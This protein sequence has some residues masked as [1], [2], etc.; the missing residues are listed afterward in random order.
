MPGISNKISKATTN[1]RR[2]LISQRQPLF[3]ARIS[4]KQAEE[5]EGDKSRPALRRPN[6]NGI[7]CNIKEWG[8][9][10]TLMQG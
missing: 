4:T 6:I 3:S 1:L 7:Y 10:K 2:E 8:L 9:L 5:K